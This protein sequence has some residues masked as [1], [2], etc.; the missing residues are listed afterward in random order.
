MNKQNLLQLQA[1]KAAKNLD[2]PSAISI[3]QE[4]IELDEQNIGA[5]NR[6]GV[7]YLQTKKPRLAKKAFEQALEVDNSNPIAKKHLERIKKKQTTK[8]PL[9]SK[10]HFI[11]EPGKT[12]I[13]DLHRL[14]SKSV[15]KD[16]S[17]SQTCQLKPKNRYLSVVLDDNTYIGAL[18]DDLSFQLS[19]LIKRN[20][21]YSCYIYSVTDKKC[22][23]YIKEEERS[24]DNRNINSFSLTKNQSSIGAINDVDERFLLENDIPVSIVET[25]KDDVKALKDVNTKARA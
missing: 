10:E 11:E 16:L 3:N 9:F 7:S 6:L 5:F 17:V 20:N 18:P 25:D 12:K 14:A 4:I 19:K 1:V 15:L 2:W 24:K 22:R 21:T 13:V 23:V 8:A